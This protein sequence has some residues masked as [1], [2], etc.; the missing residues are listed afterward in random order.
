MPAQKCA[1]RED[2]KAEVIPNSDPATQTHPIIL[3]HP[4]RVEDPKMEVSP[5]GDFVER[6]GRRGRYV[7]LFIST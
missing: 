3:G 4:V 7:L 6:R 1:L 5:L 2:R